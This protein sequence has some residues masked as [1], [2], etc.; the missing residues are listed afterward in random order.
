MASP[1]HPIREGDGVMTGRSALLAQA[2]MAFV[3]VACASQERGSV[4]A[5]DGGDTC[6]FAGSTDDLEEEAAGGLLR[7]SEVRHEVVQAGCEERMVFIFNSL[8]DGAEPG[9]FVQYRTAPFRG[10]TGEEIEVGGEALLEIVL[11]ALGGAE[12]SPAADAELVVDIVK[13]PELPDGSFWLIGL[14]EERPLSISVERT[15]EPALI[16]TI[17]APDDS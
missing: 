5:G 17:G 14:E 2:A 10:P 12:P 3:L 8:G 9:Y 6:D 15:P 11:D 16:V 13:P 4:S 7:I 1:R